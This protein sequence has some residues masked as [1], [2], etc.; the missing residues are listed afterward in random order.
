MFWCDDLAAPDHIVTENLSSP[1]WAADA[2]GGLLHAAALLGHAAA[3]QLLLQSAPEAAADGDDND[4]LPLHRAALAG[5]A[6]VV[7]LLLAA[8]PAAALEAD[9]HGRL[10]LHHA[11]NRGHAEAAALLFD[12]APAAALATDL[13]GLLPLHRAAYSGCTPAVAMLLE[14]APQA[15]WA[16][17]DEGR[18]PL[19]EACRDAAVELLLAAAPETASV[20]DDDDT[21]PIH[22]ASK[23]GFT[24][25]VEQLL[26]VAP[27]TA[28]ATDHELQTP[29]HKAVLGGSET[30]VRVLLQVAPETA[31]FRDADDR[32]PLSYALR[33]HRRWQSPEFEAIARLLVAATPRPIA[34]V[35][36]R[37]AGVATLSFF[38]EYVAAHLP[39]YK[40]EWELVPKECPD[41]GRTLPA[42]LACS[43]AQAAQVTRRLEGD[44]KL[45]LRTFSLGLA[46]L[47]RRT[48]LA[49]PAELAGRLMA[50]FDC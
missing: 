40:P 42:A 7:S 19:H 39:L 46:R 2:T 41:L 21:L 43:P 36:L 33:Y 1:S 11:A 3:T 47:Q 31:D 24:P 8:H 10:P 38:T 13:D 14:A 25:V 45:R 50:M 6:G 44:D 18:L 12:A 15:A 28:M 17:A 29:L 30:T 23:F 22:L 26:R 16:A 4:C 34:L 49:L 5:H 27:A 37:F 35:E 32:C 20:F 9:E 48:G